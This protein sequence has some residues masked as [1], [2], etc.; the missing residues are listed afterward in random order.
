VGTRK[1]QTLG[2]NFLIAQV[3]SYRNSAGNPAY[4]PNATKGPRLQQVYPPPG[5][6]I[7]WPPDKTIDDDELQVL[8][9]RFQQVFGGEV[10]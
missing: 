8:D 7:A 3:F 9:Y 1:H 10:N 4:V 6:W 5:A 2:A